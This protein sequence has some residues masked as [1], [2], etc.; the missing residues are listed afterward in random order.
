MVKG[1]PARIP[2]IF[3]NWVVKVLIVYAML[4]SF[5]SLLFRAFR[6]KEGFAFFIRAYEICFA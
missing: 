4:S 1:I 6:R 3:I 2:L 5:A